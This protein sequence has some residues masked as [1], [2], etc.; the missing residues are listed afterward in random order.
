MRR[1]GTIES[2]RDDRHIFR[3]TLSEEARRLG[4]TL[5]DEHLDALTAHFELVAKWNERVR[6][7][8]TTDPARAAIEL[9]ADSLVV[10]QF[11]GNLDIGTPDRDIG[12]N[13]PRRMIDIGPGAGLPGIPIKIRRAG[14]ILAAIESNAKKTSFL[15]AALR[16][17]RLEGATVV[18]GRAEELAHREDFREQF[19]IAFCRAIASPAFACELAVPFLKTSGRF[20][21]QT[22]EAR[23]LETIRHAAH[24]LNATICKTMTY[25]LTG[26]SI[27]RLLVGVKKLGPTASLY[28]RDPK[29]ARKRPLI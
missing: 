18:R 23:G 8:G 2:M 10:D 27:G 28:P 15:K 16:E 20:V 29:I 21:A 24:A 7:V 6:L 4:I 17:L 13:E 19:D 3:A 5:A 11:I 14:W 9:F 25:T 1:C 22:S 26:V 12:E